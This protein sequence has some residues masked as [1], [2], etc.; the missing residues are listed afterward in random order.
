VV[1]EDDAVQLQV[2]SLQLQAQGL[3]PHGCATPE[4][5]LRQIA[6][7]PPGPLTVLMD[8]RMPQMQPL[9]FCRQARTLAPRVRIVGCSASQPEAEIVA[10]LDQFLLK[11]VDGAA[12]ARAILSREEQ[13]EATGKKPSASVAAPPVDLHGE[14][15]DNLARSMSPVMLRSL[16]AAYFTDAEQR[17]RAMRSAQAGGDAEAMQRSAHTL[18]GASG[19]LGVQAVAQAAFAVETLAAKSLAEA[20]LLLDELQ[21]R[22]E[23][24]H[25]ATQ[26]KLDTLGANLAMVSPTAE[27]TESR[28]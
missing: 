19:M 26:E 12:L 9:E 13:K 27:A 14:T 21:Q 17:L 4:G 7:M 22:L 10:A 28:K 18:K 6:A 2:M 1:L 20:P 8:L 3:E 15:F 23:R 16:Y 25:N 24:A 11:P 5:A